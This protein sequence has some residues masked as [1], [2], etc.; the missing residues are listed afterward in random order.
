MS[1]RRLTSRKRTVSHHPRAGFALLAVMVAVVLLATGV[2][3]I[4]AANTTRIRTQTLST[5]RTS[6]LNVARTYL[7]NV[8]GR[9]AWSLASE[10]AV[11]V[12]GSGAPNPN[13]EFTREL[14]V[15]VV[16]M[17][18]LQLEVVVTTPRLTAPVRLLTSAY[19]GGTM[20]PT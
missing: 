9:D 14:L 19:R 20:V 15:T 4:G 1:T 17:N 3:A 6:A 10:S 11:R 5:S 12:D 18:L 13:G 8:R 2:M 16:R 7:E